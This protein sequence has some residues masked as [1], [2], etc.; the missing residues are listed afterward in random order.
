MLLHHKVI[1]P[2]GEYNEVAWVNIPHFLYGDFEENIN[3]FLLLGMLDRN[4]NIKCHLFLELCGN[5]LLHLN[6]K[7]ES[8]LYF[9]FAA[10]F[11]K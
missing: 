3:G 6:I 5:F 1:Y 4:S 2:L 8:F 9:E 10:Q 11:D 7:V